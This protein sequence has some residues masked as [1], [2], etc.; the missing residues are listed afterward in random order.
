MT[1]STKGILLSPFWWGSEPSKCLSVI[2]Y[3]IK[4]RTSRHNLGL[5]CSVVQPHHEA[6][7]MSLISAD[8]VDKSLCLDVV[9]KLLDANSRTLSTVGGHSST[10]GEF[11]NCFMATH[12]SL[13]R[14]NNSPLVESDRYYIALMVRVGFIVIS[15]DHVY[16]ALCTKA[17]LHSARRWMMP[18]REWGGNLGNL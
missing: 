8:S 15:Y 10:L 4:T 12:S 3:N 9:L 16:C 2:K 1:A 13:L 11:V 14:D 5:F 18:R 17:K 7:C 6:V